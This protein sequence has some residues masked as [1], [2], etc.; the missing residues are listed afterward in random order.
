MSEI[1]H[2]AVTTDSVS[3]SQSDSTVFTDTINVHQKL[4]RLT[5][6]ISVVAQSKFKLKQLVNNCY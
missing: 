1:K 2:F 4:T 6:E 3:R 5:R